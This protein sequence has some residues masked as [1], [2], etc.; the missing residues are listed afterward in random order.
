MD[1]LKAAK[2]RFYSEQSSLRRRFL[3]LYTEISS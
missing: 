1:V 2:L 3:I